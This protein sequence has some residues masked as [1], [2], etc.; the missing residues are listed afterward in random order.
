MFNLQG[1]HL[2][3]LWWQAMPETVAWPGRELLPIVLAKVD[4]GS[5]S[6]EGS[7]LCLYASGIMAH[8][9]LLIVS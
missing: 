5:D 6:V 3:G 9:S 1:L 8:Q 7:F 2:K 4:Q